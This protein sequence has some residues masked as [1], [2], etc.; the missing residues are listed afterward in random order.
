M[1]STNRIVLLNVSFIGQEV[2]LEFLRDFEI[3]VSVNAWQNKK[4]GQYLAVYL[5]D[6]AKAFYHQQDESVKKSFNALS[7]VL[8]ETGG[9][10]LSKYKKDFNRHARNDGETLHSYLSAL[11]LAYARAYLPPPVNPTWRTK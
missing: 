6:E 2:V 4:A 7:K 3:F 5:K 9:L 10:A 11:R 1:G 8:I